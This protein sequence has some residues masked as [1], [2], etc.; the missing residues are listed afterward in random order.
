MKILKNLLVSSIVATLAFSATVQADE[1][2]D[3]IHPEM[4]D[5]FNLDNTIHSSGSTGVFN[6]NDRNASN[7]DLVWSYEYEE[8]VN[9]SDFHSDN[10]L[11]NTQLVNRFIEENPTAAGTSRNDIFKYDENYGGY[12]LQ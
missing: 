1:L 7:S 10:N 8:F 6:L 2:M 5:V 9:E 11:Y 12:M 4:A 3:V